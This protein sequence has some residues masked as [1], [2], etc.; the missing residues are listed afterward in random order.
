MKAMNKKNSYN[1]YIY[2]VIAIGTA[3]F[4]RSSYNLP[5]T[6]LGLPFLL[7]TLA[8]LVIASRL[9]VP[10]FR[11]E[12]SI[13]IS[14]TFIFAAL[15][16]FGG[17]A[18]IV[19]GAC[20]SFL[21]SMRVT[22]RRL[23]MVFNSA[24]M[25]CS[26]YVTSLILQACFGPVERLA[27]DNFS[28]DFLVALCVMA[29]VQYICNSGTVAIA[30]SL[31]NNLPVWVTWKKHYIWTSITYFAGASAAG[32]IVRLTNTVGFYAFAAII[33][34]LFV[35]YLTYT[36]YVK[37]VASSRAQAESEQRFHRAFDLA[38]IG[39]A[40]TSP[41]GRWLQVNNSLCKIVGYSEEE[42]LE[43][44]FQAITHPE[45]LNRFL[46]QTQDVLQ[47]KALA[48][49]VEKRYYHKL[50]HEVWVL[51]GISLLSDT[52]ND[53]S[54]LIFQIQDITDRKR[55]EQQLL[56][57]VN[58]DALTSLPNRVWFVEQLDESLRNI[59]RGKERLFAVLFLDLDR[60]KII[61]DSIGHMFGDQLLVAISERLRNCI[62]QQDKIARLGGDEFT[63]LVSGIRSY[64]EATEVAERVQKEVS[65]PFC[66]DGYE[67]FTTVSIG[68]AFSNS[69]YERPD[70]LLRDADT[71]MYQAKSAGKAQYAI[72]DK[73][74]HT[75]AVNRLR[76]ETDLRRALERKEFFIEYQPIVSLDT[77]MIKG[78][79]ALL[80]WQHPNMGV[81]YPDSF[82]SVA[83]E[84]GMILPLGSWVLL[85]AC[86]QMSQW[87]RQTVG[88][89]PLFMSVNL[90]SKQFT[91]FQ[92]LDQ[93]VQILD[94][95]GIEPNSL[96]LEIIE[97]VVMENV[98]LAA[99]KLSQLRI[100]GVGLSI[101]DFGTGYSSLSYLH[102]LPIDTLKIDRSFVSNIDNNKENREIVRTIIMLARNLNLEVIAEG[103][104]KDEQIERLRELRCNYG[105]G[106]LFSRAISGE[107]AS[108]LVLNALNEISG[109]SAIQDSQADNEAAV[110]ASSLTM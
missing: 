98:E 31:W 4:L 10:F 3:I 40:L 102:R 93:I 22:K 67:T 12:S 41:E 49:Q 7:L 101:D 66:L 90:S 33:P 39:M 11:F 32:I 55:A 83:E 57:E 81:L 63:I 62:R 72:F 69:S 71:A 80:R 74:M 85:E 54:Q 100:L 92:F 99:Q 48:H 70:D 15:L 26:T 58:H 51:V 37:N 1:L 108:K 2:V 45:D 25:V 9:V 88:K 103:I 104:E 109:F 16:L 86:Y 21:S 84:T 65:R 87:Q 34:I 77:G 79:E 46:A 23:T 89:L 52:H 36:T 50:G 107:A 56:H 14:D 105:Q 106:Y 29:L 95:T 44:N 27:H 17:E 20:E 96:Q 38:P 47:G 42:L 59:K 68:I 19:I 6:R 30:A 94:E 18:A 82:I 35:I 5:L 61:N 91:H 73:G 76:I 64:A 110:V 53:T 13:S 43:I 28:S 24:A 75:R 8:T 78:F 60:F 97:S